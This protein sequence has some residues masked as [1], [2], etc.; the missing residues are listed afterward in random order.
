[1]DIKPHEKLKVLR[2]RKRFT[3]DSLAMLLNCSQ[4]QVSRI[5][6]GEIEP[7]DSLK[8]EIEKIF[9]CTIWN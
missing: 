7:D 2:Q 6:R 3:Q 8:K 9:S 5:E 4:M 1:M